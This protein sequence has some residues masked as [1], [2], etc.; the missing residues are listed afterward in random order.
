M[1]EGKGHADCLAVVH[2][3]WGWVLLCDPTSLSAGEQ[4]ELFSS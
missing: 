4:V 3:L 1:K 2:S